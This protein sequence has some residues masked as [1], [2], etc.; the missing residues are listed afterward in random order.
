M[1]W[2]GPIYIGFEPREERAYHA[3]VNSLRTNSDVELTIKPII[4][5]KLESKGI[6]TRRDNFPD[7]VASTEFAFTRFLVPYLAEYSGW[8]LFIDCDMIFTRDVADLFDL[9]EEDKAVMVVKHDYVPKESIKM[10]GQVQTQYPRKNWSSV[11]LFNCGYSDCSSLTPKAVSNESGAFL[12][13]F[14]WCKDENIG[15]LPKTWNWLV[16]EYDKLLPSNIHY[17]NGAPF[18]P[19]HEDCDYAEE[20]WKYEDRNT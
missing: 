10:D 8:A 20:Y 15:E 14:N 19:G 1:K 12:H 5:H 11:M 7:E 9:A 13:R 6:Y 2:A 4:R 18:F 16:G 3:C 17:T